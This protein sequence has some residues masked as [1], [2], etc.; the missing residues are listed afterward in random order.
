[1]ALAPLILKK[2]DDGPEDGNPNRMI[3]PSH[4]LVWR[5]DPRPD[6]SGLRGLESGKRT[7]NKAVIIYD[8]HV[9]EARRPWP[10]FIPQG[11]DGEGVEARLLSL[12]GNHRSDIVE[13]CS[14]PKAFSWGVP[15]PRTTAC[16]RRWETFSTYVKGLRPVGKSSSGSSNPTVGWRV[17]ERD[18]EDT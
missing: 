3:A 16:S 11:P 4:G 5:K 2:V 9:G 18:E 17:L 7:K 15:T 14:R 13:E 10:K 6:R 1:V 8:H 12:R